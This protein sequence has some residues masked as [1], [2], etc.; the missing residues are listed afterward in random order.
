MKNWAYAHVIPEKLRV[1]LEK[2]IF[3]N[4]IRTTKKWAY[5]CYRAIRITCCSNKQLKLPSKYRR[6]YGIGKK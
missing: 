3:K 4:A 2:V 5:A 1:I 6:C